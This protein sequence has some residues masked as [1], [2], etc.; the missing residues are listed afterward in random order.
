MGNR[1][2]KTVVA[3]W[4]GREVRS[5]SALLL[6][7]APQSVSDHS[8]EWRWCA[9]RVPKESDGVVTVVSEAEECLV[10]TQ[11]MVVVSGRGDTNEQKPLD[12][13]KTFI[14]KSARKV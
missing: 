1:H 8:I 10:N 7:A 9:C 4:E 11:D 3:A 13:C 5:S 12:V 6:T 2:P 14:V